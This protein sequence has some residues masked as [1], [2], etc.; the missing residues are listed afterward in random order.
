[1]AFRDEVGIPG[2]IY[3][4]IR[5]GMDDR[6][7]ISIQGVGLGGDDN[8]EVL[9]LNITTGGGSYTLCSITVEDMLRLGN[10]IVKT[11]MEKKRER[12]KGNV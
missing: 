3:L 4:Y 10:W 11:A 6:A 2:G 1:M 8:P 9:N 12:G 5:A 7:D